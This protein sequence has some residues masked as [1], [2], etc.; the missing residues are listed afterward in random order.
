MS[1][2]I[3]VQWTIIARAAPQPWLTCSRCGET[4]RFRSSDKIR[5]NV[6][7]KR[8]DAWLIYK[9]TDCGGTWNRPILARRPVRTID[10]D[11]LR[12]LHTSEPM[13]TRRLAFDVEGLRRNTARVEEFDDA[14]VIKSV[15]LKYPTSARRLE[16]LCSVPEP[17]RLRVDQLLASELRLS[18]SRIQRLAEVGDL[19]VFPSISCLRRPVREGM[20]LIVGT[21]ALSTLGLSTCGRR[22]RAPP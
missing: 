6:N 2:V 17:I 5:V 19:V 14:L 3:R 11:L 12:S 1:D 18:R 9:C 15:P 10:P 8:V 20:R 7:G 13:L 4:R 16:I 22:P 21:E